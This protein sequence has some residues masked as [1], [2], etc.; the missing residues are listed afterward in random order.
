MLLPCCSAL[1]QIRQHGNHLMHGSIACRLY[2]VTRARARLTLLCLR[3]LSKH[4][5]TA[6]P[7]DARNHAGH[8][9][10]HHGVLPGRNAVLPA[11]RAQSALRGRARTVPPVTL[12]A[13]WPGGHHLQGNSS[14]VVPVATWG[15]FGA[16]SVRLVGAVSIGGLCGSGHACLPCQRACLCCKDRMC[17]KP[18]ETGFVYLTC[19]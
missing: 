15:F 8:D 6:N 1:I 11:V 12:L 2:V 13:C 14:G 18:Y 16:V 19:S 5:A 3:W 17:V 10:H 4:P 7:C 9:M